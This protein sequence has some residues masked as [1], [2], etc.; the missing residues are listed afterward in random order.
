MSYGL[1]DGLSFCRV[2]GRLIFLDLRADRYFQLPAHTEDIF[3][4]YLDDDGSAH[5]DV[6]DLVRRGILAPTADP[7]G[8][9]QA[10]F[11]ETPIRSAIERSFDAPVLSFPALLDVMAIVVS[12]RWQLKTRKL[13]AIVDNL[14]T[15]RHKK[16]EHE[17][18]PSIEQ[19]LLG[20]AG[21]FMRA[22]PYV[23]I[24]TSCLLDALS[25]VRFLARRRLHAS[26][27]FGVTS[28]PFAAHCW[29]QAGDLILNDTVGNATAHTPIRVI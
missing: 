5:V 18:T 13:Q 7:E 10:G 1:R 15:Y 21:I 23:P 16:T 25:M 8:H 11:I 26:I 19:R 28:T 4:A 27:V 9:K 14:M 3:L 20:A 17:P 29:V 12:T 2:D 24:E 22:R 6:G